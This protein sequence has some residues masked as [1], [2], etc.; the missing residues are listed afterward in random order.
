MSDRPLI[1]TATQ[2][3]YRRGGKYVVIYRDPQG[4]QRKQSADNL[5]HARALQKELGADVVRGEYRALSKETF[6]GYAPR[7]IAS[8][9]GRTVRGIGPRTLAMYRSD[10]DLDDDGQPTG[11]GAVAF[12]GRYMLAERSGP[13]S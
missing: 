3:I 5:K 6:G 7:W 1:K 4:R 10:I 13:R 12:L 9:Q 11:A 2:G 8:Y